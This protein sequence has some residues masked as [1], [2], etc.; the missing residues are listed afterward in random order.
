MRQ[1][2]RQQQQQQ[3]APFPRALA[4]TLHAGPLGPQRKAATHLQ[5]IKQL[6]KALQKVAMPAPR[7]ML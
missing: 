2:T 3:C 7:L 1:G 6:K 4:S 5:M